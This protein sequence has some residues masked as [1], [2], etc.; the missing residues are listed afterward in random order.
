MEAYEFYW[1]EQGKE[2]ELLGVL[3]ERRKSSKRITKKS[4][5]GWAEK[6]FADGSS[7]KDIFFVRVRINR[8]TGKLFCAPFFVTHQKTEK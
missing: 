2:Y 6:L 4:I 8:Y 7:T 3:P 1:A 5:M